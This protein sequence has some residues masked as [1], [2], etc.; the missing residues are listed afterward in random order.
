MATNLGNVVG[1]LRR[2]T[3]PDKK[4]IIWARP[5][6]SPDPES[7]ELLRWSYATSSWVPF[8]LGDGY[9]LPATTVDPSNTPPVSPTGGTFWLT[10]NAPGGAWNGHPYELAEWTGSS[11]VFHS[12]LL[13]AV[14]NSSVDPSKSWQYTSTGWQ[15]KSIAVDLSVYYT[16]TEIQGL[17]NNGLEWNSSDSKVQFGGTLVQNTTLEMG[18]YRIDFFGGVS[19]DRVMT[20]SPDGVDLY[21]SGEKL[22]LNSSTRVLAN[23]SGV[24]VADWSGTGFG[25]TAGASHA[26]KAMF[27]VATLTA[28]RTIAMPNDSGT[29]ALLDDTATT[30]LTKTWSIDKIKEYS[31]GGLEGAVMLTGDQTVGGSKLF[32]QPI[33]TTEVK[34]YNS[35]TSPS[36]YRSIRYWMDT[37][38][39][40]VLQQDNFFGGPSTVGQVTQV[41]FYDNS[42]GFTISNNSGV[43]NVWKTYDGG[44]SW[45]EVIIPTGFL[46]LSMVLIGS[47][48]GFL[49]GYDGS[50]NVVACVT[51]DNGDSWTL[52]TFITDSDPNLEITAVKIAFDPSNPNIGFMLG[53]RISNLDS[54]TVY[55]FLAK[56]INYGS[57]WTDISGVTTGANDAFTDICWLGSRIVLT[58]FN[59]AGITEDTYPYIWISNDGLATT[60]LPSITGYSSSDQRI[61][62][63]TT[64]DGTLTA[65]AS[66]TLG[67]I[68]K[69]TNG[70][71]NWAFLNQLDGPVKVLFSQ[72]VPN[73]GYAFA[74]QGQFYKT[75][76]G[77]ES[78]YKV[79]GTPWNPNNFSDV[80]GTISP[81]GALYLSASGVG[82]QIYKFA[83]IDYD[84]LSVLQA[85]DNYTSLLTNFQIASPVF[86]ADAVTLKYLKDYVGS[87]IGASDAVV[88]KGVINAS[89]NPNYPAASVGHLYRFSVAGK[90]GGASGVNVEFG[91]TMYCIN[92]TAAGNQAT[93]G[94]NWQIV[95]ANVD[96]VVIGPASSV[97]NNLAVLSGT[98]GKLLADSGVNIT[99]LTTFNAANRLVQLNGSNQYPALSGVN[100][101]ALNATQLTSGT[102]PLARLTAFTS[103]SAGIVP[104]PTASSGRYLKD[105][106]TW[107]A[108]LDDTAAIS[109]TTKTWSV[110][111]LT[112][113]L[114]GS[115]P[116]NGLQA[117]SA[118]VGLGGTLTQATTINTSTFNFIV[119]SNGTQSV[120]FYTRKMYSSSGVSYSVDWESGS[121]FRSSNGYRSIDWENEKLH[122]R[123][124]TI[125]LDW[126]DCRLLNATGGATKLDWILSTLRDD[127]GV[128]AGN[129]GSRGLYDAA[130]V[131]SVDWNSCVLKRTGSG[132]PTTLDWYSCY[133]QDTSGTHT[134]NWDAKILYATGLSGL[135]VGWGSRGLFASGGD[136]TVNWQARQLSK[137]SVSPTGYY[138]YVVDWGS[139]LLRD[140]TG[141]TGGVTSVDWKTRLL[142]NASGVTTLGYDVTDGVNVYRG[143]GTYGTISAQYLTANRT[144]SLPDQSGI[145]ALISNLD[146]TRTAATFS[147][148]TLQWGIYDIGDITLS[149]NSTLSTISSA[150]KGRKIFVIVG[151]GY[152][153]TI[154]PAL[155]PAAN[156][157]GTYNPAATN[158]LT[159]TCLKETSTTEY[160]AE[161]FTPSSGSSSWSALTGK[162]TYVLDQ[163]QYPFRFWDFENGI[164]GSEFSAN[165]QNGGSANSDTPPAGMEGVVKIEIST[166][167]Q[168][169][170][171]INTSSLFSKVGTGE[172][173]FEA[174]VNISALSN[175]TDTYRIRLGYINA[176]GLTLQTGVEVTH[177]VYFEY[178]S[179]DSANWRICTVDNT[180]NVTKTNTSVAVAATT[181]VKLAII[182]NAAG[183]SVDFEIN[184]TNV[185]TIATTVPVNR[186][187][188]INAYINR[189]A[190]T[191]NFRNAWIDYIRHEKSLTTTR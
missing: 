78:F 159:I 19:N 128:L 26:Y 32:T 168:S 170:G 150:V 22:A 85:V 47:G 53:Y 167:S 98:T 91:D 152:T 37:A 96:G 42:L 110:N 166:A 61:T 34:Y 43:A 20:V 35:T 114:T 189:T 30:S 8:A 180:T 29:L 137:N 40:Y 51:A 127:T 132:V 108:L 24:S 131:L 1:L 72:V 59:D 183:T 111:K 80:Y 9:I 64:S 27:S 174:F 77:G 179:A 158:Y 122:N 12:L 121:I 191:S 151:G 83:S 147:G 45:Y 148:G 103:T 115:I 101:T 141:S 21:S 161:W 52:T 124:G 173:R 6:V 84:S 105:D 160:L 120:N 153:F 142:K 18:T 178:S 50:N 102:V 117:I 164:T 68:L 41:Y 156:V 125:T 7:V 90:I 113:Y 129:W 48:N 95:Q 46:P 13:G 70:G 54:Y 134:V 133:L 146:I 93:V 82:G 118:Q 130:G 155:I 175:G 99:M 94:A 119:Q 56:T 190:G 3:A 171:G 10:N 36:D 104:S 182:I 186:Q 73:T 144:I 76:D 5:I 184:G 172:M 143:T 185:G 107:F 55:P 23:T 57:S 38:N 17:F 63:V 138:A 162:P 123:T 97:N 187:V 109:S 74:G 100:I 14:S 49:V 65:Y 60:D 149:S 58:G 39:P 112:T 135:S 157:K 89:T 69:T 81:T 44:D 16:K 176:S 15:L 181:N 67:N 75:V 31:D 136:L 154:D 139:M 62:N 88:F 126:Q 33:L 145:L 188:G 165:A 79:S 140:D 25:L 28:N 163:R 66:D 116:T 71:N 2:E 106:G 87:Q 86:D 92:D 4:Y 169:L 11:W 177:G